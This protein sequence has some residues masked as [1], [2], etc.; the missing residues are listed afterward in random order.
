MSHRRGPA[1][2]ARVGRDPA[3]RARVRRGADKRR[4]GI[5]G[6]DKGTTRAASSQARLVADKALH[7]IGKIQPQR[8]RCNPPDHV[9]SSR[10]DGSHRRRKHA[11]T[12]TDD[13]SARHGQP[14]PSARQHASATDTSPPTPGTEPRPTRV[15][16]ITLFPW[17]LRFWL[18]AVW[19]CASLCSFEASSG[20]AATRVCC[21]R[22]LQHPPTER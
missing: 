16:L 11:S 2:R 14:P 8:I 10:W 13:A 12:M 5:A 1:A 20:P 21:H 7:P 4:K 15:V 19:A 22:T 18:L 6:N 3:A 9:Q 17:R